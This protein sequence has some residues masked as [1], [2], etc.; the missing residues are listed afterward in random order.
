MTQIQKTTIIL[1]YMLLSAIIITAT[2][3][4]IS[5]FSVLGWI[6]FGAQMSGPLYM[7]ALLSYVTVPIFIC[8]LLLHFIQGIKNN[9]LTR[10]RI[11]IFFLVLMVILTPFTTLEET[12]SVN[13]LIGQIVMVYLAI[14][15]FFA[16]LS[17]K[18]IKNKSS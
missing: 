16:Y 8:S 17:C 7:L 1:L 13:S 3:Y 11:L 18:A 9:K 2:Y 14:T 10:T 4:I 15:A 12:F 6:I 5:L